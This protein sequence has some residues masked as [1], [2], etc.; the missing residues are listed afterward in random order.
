MYDAG[1]L[2]VSVVPGL[3]GKVWSVCPQGTVAPAP[4]VGDGKNEI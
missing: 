1:V 4:S 2:V 3:G